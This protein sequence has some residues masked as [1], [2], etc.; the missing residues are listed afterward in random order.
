[1]TALSMDEPSP[2]AEEPIGTVIDHDTPGNEIVSIKIVEGHCGGSSVEPSSVWE[3]CRAPRPQQHG[4][5]PGGT[6]GW[7]VVCR[8]RW[9]SAK[10]SRTDQAPRRPLTA[11]PRSLHPKRRCTSNRAHRNGGL[12]HRTRNAPAW[13]VA[14]PWPCRDLH[15]P[16]RDLP[17]PVQGERARQRRPRQS[18]A[19]LPISR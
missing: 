13:Q 7:Q 10:A 15:A 3:G 6:W 17:G 9:Q 1:M 4:Q 2:E 12:A 5:R 18:P 16:G 19:F 8:C 11:G 14:S